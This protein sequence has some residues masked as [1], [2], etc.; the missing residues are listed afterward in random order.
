MAALCATAAAATTAANK[1]TPTYVIAFSAICVFLFSRPQVVPAIPS[2][3]VGLT[4]GLIVVATNRRRLVVPRVVLLFVVYI[5]VAGAW[6]PEPRTSILGAGVMAAIAFC[7]LAAASAIP[8]PSMIRCF[9]V[10][11]KVILVV[12]AALTVVS[13]GMGRAVAG[14]NAG[15]FVGLYGTKNM[16]ATVLTL[17]AITHFYSSEKRDARFF[18]WFFGYAVAMVT[19]SSAGAFVSILVAGIV[20]LLAS[21]ARRSRFGSTKALLDQLPFVLIFGVIVVIN[22][23]WVLGLFGRDLTFSGRDV[24]WRGSIAALEQH[25]WTGYGWDNVFGETDDAALVIW[26]YTGWYVPSSHDGLLTV[27]LQ[28]GL[29]GALFAAALMVRGVALAL[30]AYAR[31]TSTAA[32]WVLQMAVLFITSN[33]VESRFQWLM[34]F[35]AC[36]ALTHATAA[37]SDS[38]RRSRATKQARLVV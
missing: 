34:W 35:V 12:S 32:A 10:T 22:V 38:H 14:V 17:G 21:A 4:Y 29:V 31:D 15:G 5:L 3:L 24:I 30:R 7:G 33:L 28:V 11:L 25:P 9:D 20:H 1:R 27:A 23:R 6:S 16:F 36:V 13:P 37:L 19:V 2:A 18:F 26:H 8:L